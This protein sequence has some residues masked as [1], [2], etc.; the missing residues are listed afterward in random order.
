MKP[1]NNLRDDIAI[2]LRI[3]AGNLSCK[4]EE[5]VT[6]KGKST[7]KLGNTACKLKAPGAKNGI[8]NQTRCSGSP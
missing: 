3:W 8:Q 5:L 7:Y 4:N 1:N 2:C 6:V